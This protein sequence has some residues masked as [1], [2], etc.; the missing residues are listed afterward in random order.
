MGVLSTT[1]LVASHWRERSQQHQYRAIVI[2]G[3]NSLY[4]LQSELLTRSPQLANYVSSV[5]YLDIPH[6][7]GYASNV[8]ASLYD[9][10]GSMVNLSHL[11]LDGVRMVDPEDLEAAFE[12]LASLPS[13]SSLSLRNYEVDPVLFPLLVHAGSTLNSISLSACDYMKTHLPSIRPVD[14]SCRIRSIRIDDVSMDNLDFLWAC[15]SA[16]RHVTHF[17]FH[18]LELRFAAHELDGILA[19][20]KDSLEVLELTTEDPP[21]DSRTPTS[22]CHEYCYKHRR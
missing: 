18:C 20:M 8:Q 12:F 5:T 14:S 21:L 22:T 1:A 3:H 7:N 11:R 17:S 15:P 10:C 6:V 9:V 19:L 13:L 2:R 4:G 16:L